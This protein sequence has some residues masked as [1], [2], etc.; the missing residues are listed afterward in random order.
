MKKTV[1]KILC[2]L[3][4]F[5]TLGLAGC[6]ILSGF[7]GGNTTGDG[8]QTGTTGG[9][10]TDNSQS[11]GVEQLVSL[12]ESA[13]VASQYGYRYFATMKDGKKF[14][15]FY[16]DLYNAC[17]GLKADKTIT[18][19]KQFMQGE[20]GQV[21]EV[22]LYIVE[23]LDFSK[24]SLTPDEAVA[25][26]KTFRAEY[27]EFYWLDNAVTYGDETLNI[28][29]FEE[30]A[31]GSVRVNLQ[32]K[33]AAMIEDCQGYLSE[34]MTD[35]EKALTIYDYVILS[36]N[37]AYKDNANTIP[38]DAIWAHN[39][40]GIAQ[41]GK[42]VCETYAK[43]FEYLCTVNGI[44][45]ITVG[46]EAGETKA[47]MCGHAWNMVKLDGVWYTVDATWGDQE[48][49]GYIYRE[50]FGQSI[51]EFNVTHKA[52]LPIEGYGKDWQYPLPV[53]S[54]KTISP[55]RMRTNDEE[56]VYACIDYAFT[57]ITDEQGEY[58]ITLHP[59]TAVVKKNKEINKQNAI[60]LHLS[61]V[62]METAMFPKAEQITFV[63]LLNG[64]VPL[65]MRSENGVILNSK[66]SL[67]DIAWTYPTINKNGYNIEKSTFS[68]YRT[69]S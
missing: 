18:T 19:S 15:D 47:E 66:I 29:I 54:G 26:W 16:A 12:P 63:G 42:G 13:S 3:L 45:A 37:Y 48:Y 68:S 28:Q 5:A 53:A 32:G 65:D 40:V 24:Y 41:K 67:K 1:R 55:V 35:V 38:E 22:Y 31:P 43:A 61:K 25:V 10:Q 23:T 60:K 58:V 52:S 4:A 30:Y 27:P 49:I 2:A 56:K 39:L 14:C 34:E 20:N 62:S 6:D 11:G 17:C 36:T 57:N 7:S 64:N 21:E 51:T 9:N 46:G 44:E 50:W 59:E 8:T 69:E 33:I